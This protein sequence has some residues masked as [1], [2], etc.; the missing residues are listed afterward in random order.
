MTELVLFI[1]GVGALSYEIVYSVLSHWVKS[2]FFLEK[3]YPLVQL[4]SSPKTYKKLFPKWAF[5]VLIPVVL[6]AVIHRGLYKML[7]CPYCVAAEL[8]FWIPLLVLDESI[9]TSILLTGCALLSTATYNLIR[10]KAI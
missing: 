2:L 7:Q 9:I 6:V 3:E 10:V 5:P 4:L 8:G 1:L